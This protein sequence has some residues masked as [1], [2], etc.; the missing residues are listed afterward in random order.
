MSYDGP[1]VIP[2]GKRQIAGFTTMASWWPGTGRGDGADLAAF[3]NH[4]VVRSLL[5]RAAAAADG[6]SSPPPEKPWPLLKQP[7]Y[8]VVLLSTAYL[9]VAILGIANNS[10][11][12]A[13]IYRQPRMRTVTN[14]FLSN[15]AT[16][17]ILVCVLVMPI[18]LLQNVFT[19]KSIQCL[20]TYYSNC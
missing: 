4:T 5:D 7:L 17:D 12:V 20:Y 13:V 6:P 14:Y 11:V 18:T 10:L 15:L 19:G 8:A 9:I 3:F 1:G 16:A 2:T